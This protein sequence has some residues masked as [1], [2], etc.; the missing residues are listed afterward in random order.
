MDKLMPK[1][2]GL[3][4]QYL[5]GVVERRERMRRRRR[6][7]GVLDQP[8]TFSSF[9]DPELLEFYQHVS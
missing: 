7:V 1:K 4:R 5:L 8:P 3:C 9:L 6:K 2:D